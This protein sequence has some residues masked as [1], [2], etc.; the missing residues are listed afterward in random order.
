MVSSNQST[1]MMQLY[2]DQ[3]FAT[4]Q[5]GVEFALAKI[6]GGANPCSSLNIN[7]LGDSFLGDNITVARA[8]N[9]VTVT[10]VRA[11]S[12]TTLSVTD[13]IPPSDGQLIQVDTTNVQDSGNGG[14]PRKLIGIQFQLL[15][16]CGQAVT[17]TSLT[18]S[19][20]P[21][22][23]ENIL[24]IKFDGSNVYNSVGM[25]SGS[26]IDIVDQTIA[27]ANVHTIDFIRWDADIQDRL[28]TIQFNFSDGS[29]KII[30]ID[31]T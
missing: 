18:I 21:N 13:P 19:W 25:P 4:A 11:S 1:R 14:P 30:Q 16:G 7:F 15:P 22:N 20:A 23:V 6:Y 10:G 31:L 29:N 26:T 28:Y 9:K 5:A 8:N 24:Q 2:S 17:I 3:S 12:T 27:D